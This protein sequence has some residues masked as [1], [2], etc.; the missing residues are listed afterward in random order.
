VG[1][2]VEFLDTTIFCPFFDEESGDMLATFEPFATIG[3]D[4]EL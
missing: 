2:K 1:R 3:V 4:I